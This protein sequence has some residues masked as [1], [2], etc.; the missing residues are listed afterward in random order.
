MN[1]ICQSLLRQSHRNA[2]SLVAGASASSSAPGVL[3]RFF[4]ADAA[5]GEAVDKATLDKLVRTNKVVVFMK[6][7]PQ[8][9]RCGFSNAVV[10]IMRMHGVQYDAHD[11]LQNESLRQGVKDYT[12]WPTIPQVFID[13]EFVGGCDILL[14]MHQSGDL[15][16]ELKKVG[17]VS[18]L[19]KAEQAKQEDEKAK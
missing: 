17:I 11:V 1:R 14:Q 16:E 9:P 4:A 5:T 19:L 7:N 3:S 13:G 18:E 15:I 12:D 2:R 8:A 10:Q 6:G